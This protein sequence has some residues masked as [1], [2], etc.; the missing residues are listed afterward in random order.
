MPSRKHIEGFCAASHLP[1][2]YKCV[3]GSGAAG[4]ICSKFMDLVVPKKQ[5]FNI[6]FYE[7]GNK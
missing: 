7:W 5:L 2:D 1:N 3:D 4:L 6:C